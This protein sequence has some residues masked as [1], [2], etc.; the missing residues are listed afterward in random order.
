[1]RSNSQF[2]S[3]WTAMTNT[4]ATSH[5]GAT[6]PIEPTSPY[7]PDSCGQSSASASTLT[8]STSTRRRGMALP[9]VAEV[10]DGG[11]AEGDEVV[12]RDREHVARRARG[13]P[14]R[15]V[16]EKIPID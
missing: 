4:M 1:M 13:G 11:T 7:T 8:R 3:I 16:L 15:V 5:P 14:D 10:S 9:L 12:G 2:D 6:R